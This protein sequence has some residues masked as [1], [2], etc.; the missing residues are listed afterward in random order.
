MLA[1]PPAFGLK[2]KIVVALSVAVL[3]ILAAFVSYEM[4]RFRV[5][6][7]GE[8]RATA[9]NLANLYSGAVASSVWEF[10]KDNT[11]S[12][13]EALRV[14]EGF[15]R[16]VIWETNGPEFVAVSNR[17]ADGPHVEGKA[18]IF[19]NGKEIA[20]IL[21][22]LSRNVVVAAEERHLQQ[23]L[24]TVGALAVALLTSVFAAL[25]FLTR[26]LDRMTNLMQR[27]A[28]GQLGGQIPFVS[29]HDEVGRMAQALAVFRDHAIERRNAE[30]A[31]Q[32]RTEELD[33]LNKDLLKARD[34][35]ESAN[36][37]KSEF[38]ASMSHEIRTPM[39]GIVG[40]VHV[41][42]STLLQPD[43]REKL[44]TLASAASTLLS[45]LNDILDISKI[46]AGRLELDVAPFRPRRMLDDMM[47]LWRP[48]ALNKGL[49]L[50]SHVDPGVP[51]L[52]MGDA[53]RIGQIV[54]NYLGNAIKFTERGTVT[55]HLSGEPR[56]ERL[57]RLRVSVTDTGIGI[58]PDT[59]PRLFQKF[60]QADTSTTRKFGGTGLGLAI[61][62]ELAQLMG[63]QVGVDSAPGKGSTFWF[64][65]DSPIADATVLPM[66]EAGTRS[67]LLALP[68]ERRLNL[69]V[70]EDNHVN[71]VVIAS[72]LRTAGHECDIAKDGAEA[73][74]SVQNSRYDGV[75]MDI[76]MPVIDG[77]EA[78][79]SIRK[80]GGK[81]MTLPI[82]A[83]TANA[84]AGDEERY[85]GLG[86]NDYVPKPI[87]P[88]RL[89]L[90]LRRSI[91]TDAAPI[92]RAD[93]RTVPEPAASSED[94]E[95][96]KRLLGSL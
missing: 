27:F 66:P 59:M 54:A 91:A 35:A 42:M 21:V 84:M 26:P 7:M 76:Q 19:V 77:V 81:Y 63:G 18:K 68:G 71:Q 92:R 11:R 48:S 61:C 57:Y 40:M 90:A 16:A 82:I 88:D 29:R 44:S 96:L 69:L 75:L 50:K 38:L 45:I 31:L 39:N 5:E 85:L 10:D 43:Q 58:D 37:I 80:L 47:A 34:A 64:A 95:D 22:R 9:Q 13:L 46:E 55:V 12:Q 8:L 53:N 17:I 72:M 89:T 20:W 56:G 24:Y 74:A 62:R 23:I 41:L 49:G 32:R 6:R 83:L 25:H 52:L 30:L 70:V 36:R 79:R 87:D 78:T 3:A 1:R 4:E 73:I 51:P 28:T 60:S 94:D 93:L 86:M 15:Q 2:V 65:M 33:A 14:V 67:R